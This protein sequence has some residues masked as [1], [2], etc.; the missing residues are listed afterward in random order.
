MTGRARRRCGGD[1]Q[2]TC[3]S[4]Q[5]AAVVV[6]AVAAVT[7]IWPSVVL[8]HPVDTFTQT[9]APESVWT[10][11]GGGLVEL[12]LIAVPAAW[13]AI[14]V[15]ALWRQA[16]T[17]RGVTR[18]QAASFAAGMLALFIALASPID[19][20]AEA[21][22]S[23]HMLQHLLLILVAAPLCVLGAP[24]LPMLWALPRSARRRGGDWWHRRAVLRRV[25]YVATAPGMVFVLHT[26][27]LWFWHFPGPYQ[28]ALR[29]PFV[30]ALEHLSFF[31]TALLFWWVVAQPAGRRRVSYPAAILL[32][33]GTLM[34]SGALGAV[35]MFAHSPWYPAHGAG[36]RA[37]GVTLLGDQ[38]L[39]G[40]IMW[41]PAGF[42][43]VGAAA[44]L[45]LEWMRA[46]ERL[47]N[48]APRAARARRAALR[49]EVV[50]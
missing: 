23:V 50:K 19:A 42:I 18:L 2:A 26:V 21:L 45:F 47:S 1:R 43:Y 32:I 27:A 28:T 24:L 17:G 4:V 49:L 48:T 39:A 14:G 3:R 7:S 8:A 44:L 35:L 5:L 9:L 36:A 10:H 31:G 34:Q 40:L 37:W 6:A 20:L 33:G 13:Y 16:G 12:L 22:F 38:Q 30:H 11:W 41:I 25:V 46:D 15:R 29:D